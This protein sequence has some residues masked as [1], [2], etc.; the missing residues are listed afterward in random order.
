MTSGGAAVDEH[1]LCLLLWL[2]SFGGVVLVSL[3]RNSWHYLW[4][5]HA[6]MN[7]LVQCGISVC[8]SC[9]VHEELV[10]VKCTHQAGL[11]LPTSTQFCRDSAPNH[12]VCLS[13]LPEASPGQTTSITLGLWALL[14]S[15][16][17]PVVNQIP[18]RTHHIGLR[19][20]F[21]SK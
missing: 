7:A 15:W 17:N 10:L 13:C 4:E 9:S 19:P 11:T 18:G 6:M 8:F 16:E 5:H 1:I 12:L 2:V 3:P 21:F 20:R 14:V